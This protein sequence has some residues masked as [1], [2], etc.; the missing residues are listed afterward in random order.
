LRLPGALSLSESNCGRRLTQRNALLSDPFY[1]PSPSRRLAYTASFSGC[2]FLP[3]FFSLLFL[4]RSPPQIVVAA[5]ACLLLFFA[6]DF[7]SRP[8]RKSEVPTNMILSLATSF[9][10]LFSAPL[11]HLLLKEW[12]RPVVDPLLLLG[13]SEDRLTLFDVRRSAVFL[14]S[15]FLFRPYAGEWGRHSEPRGALCLSRENPRG[16]RNPL[17]FFLCS[18]SALSFSPISLIENTAL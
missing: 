11:L 14:P 5:E 6:L 12:K 9:F 15:R 7:G 10:F 16:L 13:R 8:A 2:P 18:S 3:L 4:L 17:L 1:T